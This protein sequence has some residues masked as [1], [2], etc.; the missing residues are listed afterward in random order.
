MGP[1]WS[2]DDERAKEDQLLFDLYGNPADEAGF[3]NFKRE[4]RSKYDKLVGEGKIHKSYFFA[5]EINVPPECANVVK[6]ARTSY[7]NALWGWSD[8]VN[9]DHYLTSLKNQP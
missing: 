7:H 9:Y 5:D 3:D 8:L 6:R 1:A 2:L 4:T